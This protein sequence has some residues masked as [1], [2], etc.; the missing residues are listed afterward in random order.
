MASSGKVIIPFFLLLLIVFTVSVIYGVL[1]MSDKCTGDDENA[2][3]IIDSEGDCNFVRCKDDTHTQDALGKCVLDQSGED[4]T[5]EGTPKP[6][7][8]YKTNVS[9]ECTFKGC[10]TGYEI[11]ENGICA[12]AEAEAEAEAGAGAGAGAEAGAEAEADEEEVEEENVNCT[13]TLSEWGRCSS[14]CKPGTQTRT[15]DVTIEE[16]G[17]GLCDL[18]DEPL[19]QDCNPELDCYDIGDHETNFKTLVGTTTRN[20]YGINEISCMRDSSNE[21]GLNRFKL[22]TGTN[23]TQINYEYSCLEHGGGESDYDDRFSDTVTT[24]GNTTDLDA[25]PVD[26]GMFPIRGFQWVGTN[27]SGA[28]YRY[29]C[30]DGRAHSGVCRSLNTEWGTSSDDVRYLKH[31]DVKCGEEE[32]ISKFQLENNT[33]GNKFRYNYKCCQMGYGAQ[34]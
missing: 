1:E 11:G 10:I 18:R 28:R 9:G 14:R 16:S 8:I 21:G 4:C 25:F 3:Y 32:V 2:E 27:N 33:D 29:K 34:N 19:E 26:C 24:T 30:V 31:H 5:P 22:V 15:L 17:E 6:Y 7:G 12:E 20:L 23:D 13:A